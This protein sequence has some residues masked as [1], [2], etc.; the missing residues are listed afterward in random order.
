[1]MHEY[2][3]IKR[4]DG[5]YRG[6]G[7]FGPRYYARLY[8]TRPFARYVLKHMRIEGHV[9]KLVHVRIRPCSAITTA[10]REFVRLYGDGGVSQGETREMLAALDRL[11]E[12][13]R[14]E[15]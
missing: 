1:M 4:A 3:L 12:V 6:P 11:R 10:A 14:G 2:W 7:G 9:V 5:L 8:I 15:Q 13:V